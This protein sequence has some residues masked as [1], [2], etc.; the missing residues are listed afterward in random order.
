MCLEKSDLQA[1]LKNFNFLESAMKKL[2]DFD[3]LVG[4]LANKGFDIVVAEVKKLAPD[5]DLALAYTTFEVAIEEDEDK[6]A[7]AVQDNA[8]IDQ[9][10]AGEAA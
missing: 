10:G 9:Q 5:L 7:D 2:P 3:D 8:R 6:V 1:T 4:D